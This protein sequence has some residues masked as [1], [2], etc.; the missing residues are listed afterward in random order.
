MDYDIIIVS[1]CIIMYLNITQFVNVQPSILIT[2][3]V[4]PNIA[5]WE[6]VYD[7]D[8]DFLSILRMNWKRKVLIKMGNWRKYMNQIEII[9]YGAD[10]IKD[11]V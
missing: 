11:F 3:Q 8:T 6:W 2:N 9:W 1:T 7:I 10:F 5:G 4:Q